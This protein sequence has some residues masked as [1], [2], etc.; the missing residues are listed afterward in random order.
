MQAPGQGQDSR[1]GI[2]VPEAGLWAQEPGRSRVRGGGQ[3]QQA[4]GCRG[5]REVLRDA[6]QDPVLEE[7]NIRPP[8]V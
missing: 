1:R 7:W 6:G 2:R 5:T 8:T 3:A 4:A